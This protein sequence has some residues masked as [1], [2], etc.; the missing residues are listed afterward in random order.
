MKFYADLAQLDQIMAFLR[1]EALKLGM[2]D[3]ATHKMELACE[4]AIVNIISYA[5][6][7]KKGELSIDCKKNGSRF[8]VTLCDWGTPFNPIEAE[9][10]PQLNEPVQERRIGGLGIYLLRKTIDEASYQRIDNANIL[11]LVFAI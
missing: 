11:R 6:P 8:E 5:Y 2:K 10:H 4:E 7:G 1:D 9:L 3:K